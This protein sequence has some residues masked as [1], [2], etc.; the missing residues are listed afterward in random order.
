[1][2]RPRRVA[3]P[4]S[5]PLALAPFERGLQLGDGRTAVREFAAGA[6]RRP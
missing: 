6:A 5:D 4:A 3:D 1:V 2:H